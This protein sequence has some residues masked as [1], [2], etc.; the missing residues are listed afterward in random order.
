MLDNGIA[1][2]ASADAHGSLVLVGHVGHQVVANG[3]AGADF[4]FIRGVVR[5]VY[6]CGGILGELPK[7]DSGGAQFIEYVSFDDVIIGS[8]NEIE[9]CGRHLREYTVANLEMVRI[10]DPEACVRTP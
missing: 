1:G 2:V 7:H 10:F 3:V 5:D 6:F 8:R 4:L 9:S